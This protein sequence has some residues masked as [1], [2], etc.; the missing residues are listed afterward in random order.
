[1]NYKSDCAERHGV[2]ME[3]KNLVF[4]KGIPV[5]LGIA[6]AQNLNAMN[7][8]ASLEDVKK[9]E[10]IDHTHQI[11]SKNEMQDYVSHIADGNS[12]R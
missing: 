7:Y 4:G 9:K 1:M 8:F 5:G 11:R 10:I 12:F 2:F 6:L 3:D